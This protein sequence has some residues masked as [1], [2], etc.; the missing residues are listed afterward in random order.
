MATWRRP[1]P[2]AGSPRP[3]LFVAALVL[4]VGL[5]GYAHGPLGPSPAVA[6]TTLTVNTTADVAPDDGTD[7]VCSLR[8]AVRFANDPANGDADCGADGGAPYTVLLQGGQTYGLTID[9]AG[10]DAAATGDL[11]ITAGL[12]AIVVDGLGNATVQQTAADRVFQVAP[13]AG[14]ALEGITVTGGREDDG[15][16]IHNEG[17]AT[18]TAST[19]E[20]N[21][22]VLFGGGI[23]NAGGATLGL[24]GS[25]VSGSTAEEGGGIRNEFGG[26]VELS[27]SMVSFNEAVEF[28]GGIYSDGGHVTLADSTVSDNRAGLHGGG[29]ISDLFVDFEADVAFPGELILVRSSV[30]RNSAG[31]DGGGIE[32]Y[33]RAMLTGSTVSGNTSTRSGGG[34]DNWD[35]DLRGV[36]AV[37]TLVDSTVSDNAGGNGGGILADFGTDVTLVRSVVSGNRATGGPQA[38]G[39]GGGIANMAGTELTLVNSTVSGNTANDEGGGIYNGFGTVRLTNATVAFNEAAFGG[40]LWEEPEDTYFLANTIIAG[41]T[42]DNCDGN[43]T[44]FESEGHNLDSDGTCVD[45]SVAG[46]ISAGAAL[47]GLLADNGGPTQT[48]A[49]LPGSEAID[50]GDEAVCAA[51]LVDGVDQSGVTRPQ[52]GDGDALAVCD[53]GAFELEALEGIVNRNTNTNVIGIDN[54]NENDNAN[55]NTNANDNANE[56][57][58]ENDNANQNAQDQDN[59]QGQDNTNQQQNNI[60]SSPE[61]NIRGR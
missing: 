38:E 57:T 3:A 59:D 56:N 9:G 6:A 41:N 13:G 5:L 53:I 43:G 39:D 24:I 58:N 25:N 31:Q 28:G 49:P 61:V 22:A 37:L 12:V 17:T 33:G 2:R 8:A 14:L 52:D 34:I 48:H 21:E 35:G 40:G 50:A 7:G 23:F 54:A 10:E 16:G 20:I 32:N 30:L 60:D 27:D 26:T 36:N 47:L 19:V 1:A 45:G 11:D 42:P 18:L 46:D 15:G 4:V 29:I 51:A 55:G 44:G